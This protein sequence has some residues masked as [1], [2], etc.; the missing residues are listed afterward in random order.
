MLIKSRF[1]NIP[2]RN[3]RGVFVNNVNIAQAE[4]YKYLGVIIDERLTFSSV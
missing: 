3:H 2:T 1:N 4:Q